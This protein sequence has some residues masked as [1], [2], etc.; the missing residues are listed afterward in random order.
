MNSIPKVSAE[1]SAH[2]A[3][4]EA[5]A[6]LRSLASGVRPQWSGLLPVPSRP[7]RV[8]GHNAR[9]GGYL[10]YR[11]SQL[12]AQ[13]HRIVV[14]EP[15][16]LLFRSLLGA[17]RVQNGFALNLEFVYRSPRGIEYVLTGYVCGYEDGRLTG[18]GWARE[19]S[20]PDFQKRR[21]AA[22]DQIV[23]EERCCMPSALLRISI[24]ACSSRWRIC[25]RASRLGSAAFLP[26]IACPAKVSRS[27]NF[28]PGG[29]LLP[30]VPSRKGKDHA[31]LRCCF[32]HPCR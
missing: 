21:G 13:G 31:L 17:R 24:C 20:C 29:G 19:C 30:P 9:V 5:A 27:A 8:P 16:R 28:R 32:C 6:S 15:R 4:A 22:R 12:A 18:T 14:A 3:A 26:S 25:G 11:Q 23:G 7:L 1:L 10:A 2:P